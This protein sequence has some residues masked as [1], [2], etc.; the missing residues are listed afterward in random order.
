MLENLNMIAT[1]LAL[2]FAGGFSVAFGAWAGI[3]L[4]S[5]LYGPFQVSA[6]T[7]HNVNVKDARSHD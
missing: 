6:N 5:H 3:K 7:N 4:G 2:G 1:V